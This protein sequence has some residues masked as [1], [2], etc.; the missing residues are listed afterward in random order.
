MNLLKRFLGKK[1]NNPQPDVIESSRKIKS[2]PEYQPQPD[3]KSNLIIKAEQSDK[4]V[5][6]TTLPIHEMRSIR[7]FVSSTFKDMIEDRNELM[8]H[9]WPELRQF[10]RERQV[11]LVEVDM[12]WGIAEEQSNRKETLKLCLNEIRA[13]QP[14]FIGLLGERYGWVPG[15]DAF[16][17]DLKEEEPWLKDLQGK[18]VTELEIMHG[19]LNN[20]DM[21][22]HA[23]FYF[24]DP[25]YAKKKCGD[26]LPESEADAEKQMK[27]KAMIRQ[28]CA[29][30]NIPLYETYTDPQSLARLVLEHLKTAI[31][32]KFPV[33]NVPNPLDREARNHEAF[34]EIRRRTYIS[35]PDYYEALDSHVAREGAPLVLLGDSGSGKTALLANWI[36]RW[37][38][39][40]PN[41][42]IFQ[43]YIGGTI[44]SAI[45]WKLIKLLIVEIK[46]WTEDRN[47]LPQTNDDILRD[48]PVWL[49]KARVKAE[50]TGVRF[51]IILDALNQ[52]DDIDHGRLLGWLPENP[53]TGALRL[54]VSTLPGDSLDVLDKRKWPAIRIQ[55]LT[56]EERGR[57][58]SEYL[59]RFGKK[60][61]DPRLNRIVGIIT[62]A[63]PLYLQI[64]L[65]ELRVTGTHDR[66]DERL[67]DYLSAMDIPSLLGKVLARYQQDYEH[68][69]KG[70]VGK[71]LGLICAARRGLSESEL[72]QLLR[73]AQ[74]P[75]LPLAT[76]AP[77]RAALEENLVNRGGIMNFAH[78]F[79]RQAVET[80]FLPNLNKKDDFQLALA[81]YFETQPISERNCDELPWL[82]RQTESF[83]RLR[84]CLLDID[85]FIL[86]KAFDE[87]ELRKY[88]VELGEV[89]NMGKQYLNSF[90]VWKEKN[91]D[92]KILIGALNLGHFLLNSALFAESE[93]LIRLALEIGEQIRYEDQG[94]LLNNLAE[95]L[96]ETNRFFEAEPLYL[97]AIKFNEIKFGLNSPELAVVLINYALLLRSTGRFLEAEPF[98][99]RALKIEEECFGINH[100]NV[101]SDMENLANLLSELKKKDEAELLL[102]GALRIYEDRFG[103]NHP[104]VGRCMG[105]LASCLSDTDRKIEA[106]TLFHRALKINED[107]LGNNHPN[108]AYDLKGIAKLLHE[109]DKLSE[110]EPLYRKALQIFED[111]F[112]KEDINVAYVMEDLALL[113]QKTN[114]KSEAEIMFKQTISTYYKRLEEN[115]PRIAFN[116]HNLANLLSEDN[117]MDEAEPL[118]RKALHLNEDRFG[119]NHPTVAENLNL[120]AVTF[121]R[122][123][124]ISE[125]EPLFRNAIKIYEEHFGEYSP[126]IAICLDNLAGSLLSSSRPIEAEPLFRRALKIYENEHKEDNLTTARCINN[127]GT[128]LF[129]TKRALEAEPLFRRALKILNEQ[130]G[131]NHPE[132][133]NCLNNL[134]LSLLTTHRSIEAEPLFRKVIEF[135]EANLS[136]NHPQ[137]A[138]YLI[139]GAMALQANNRINE[140]ATLSYRIVV[141]LT[142]YSRSNGTEDPNLFLAINY[143][144]SLLSAQG[145]NHQQIL[146]K[147]RKIAGDFLL[148]Q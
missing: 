25:E 78:D 106:A 1:I 52:L 61:D 136:P 112:S 39:T 131:E 58:V 71:A 76:W 40:H 74:L 92:T 60:L 145:F 53:F 84:A 139:N 38:K 59:A 4:E 49:S 27:L 13:C 114:R 97:K 133:I 113:L 104:E 108:V 26:F 140:A 87:V 70:L 143:Y 6:Q 72:M 18:S 3:P 81:D 50:W 122:S 15:E 141:I 28:I 83:D 88:W 67:D 46:R 100:P 56:P 41:D 12:R 142:N 96:R 17:S 16:T 66:L 86:L 68:D 128:S 32:S 130:F 34:A 14:Y 146:T 75:Q 123:N 9:A 7:V 36:D 19:A 82:F 48:F 99:R 93:P 117:R 33:E 11:E 21:A 120:L 57:M 101:A 89:K 31:G 73:P 65:D 55:P 62:A 2:E 121:I 5:K 110:A 77:L 44:D 90:I 35:R 115:N 42:F 125:A 138:E 98:Y 135:G 111:S 129:Q 144:A 94:T 30:K 43:Y 22:N 105:N 118:I 91:N 69:H 148:D 51:I 134:A 109:A 8:T 102:R 147:I 132:Y 116:L 95:L 45:H 47:E 54:I 20:P 107:S 127:L 85:R 23:F 37:R 103:N 79:L 124:R 126:K 24:R 63:N 64:L 10:C 80:A 137:L 119:K 29:L